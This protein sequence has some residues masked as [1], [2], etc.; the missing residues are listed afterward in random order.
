[1][2]NF[3]AGKLIA[4]PKLDF[5]GNPITNPT[6]VI[7]GA[8]QDVSVDLSVELKTLYGANRYPLA[9]G[10]GKAKPEIKAKYADI[11]GAALGSLFFGKTGTTGIKALA[12]DVQVTVPSASAYTVTPSVPNSGTFVADM[13]VFNATTGKQYSR[14]ANAPAAGQYTVSAGG[15]YTFASADASAALKI[16]FEYT[17]TTAG[18]VYQITN[19]LMGY[20][21]GFSIILQSKFQGKNMV[22][23]FNN[24]VSGKLSLPLKNDDFTISEFEATALDDGTG[25]IGYIALF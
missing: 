12:E 8:L 18:E 21:P 5:L 7:L 6:P 23:K 20:T 19:D 15:V 24:A 3:G 13:G 16:S 22:V 25:S 4:V 11:S 9:V 1:M 17:S 14:V 10:Q 2:Y